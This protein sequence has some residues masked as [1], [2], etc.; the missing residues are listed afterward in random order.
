MFFSNPV[1]K[2][3]TVQITG[4]KTIAVDKFFALVDF[5]ITLM[6]YPVSYQEWSFLCISDIGMV[7]GDTSDRGPKA[8]GALFL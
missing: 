6:R 2:G 4:A 8:E 5:L 1:D 3:A 7:R